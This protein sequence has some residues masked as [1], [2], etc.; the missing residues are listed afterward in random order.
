LRARSPQCTHITRK[1]SVYQYRRR[2]PAPHSGEVMLSLG[3][4]LYREAEHR[5]ALLDETFSRVWERVV[6]M[7]GGLAEVKRVVREYLRDALETDLEWRATRRPGRALFTNAHEDLH[8]TVND[9]DLDILDSLISDARE[10]LERRDFRSVRSTADALLKD[11]RLSEDD[12]NLLSLGLLEANLKYLLEARQRSLGQVSMVLDVGPEPPSVPPATP[13][14]P[15]SPVPPSPANAPAFSELVADFVAWREKSGVRGHTLAQDRPT[16]RFFQEL[17]GDRPVN[18][19]GR[20]DVTRFLSKIQEF[21]ASYGKSPADHDRSAAEIIARANEANAKRVSAKTAKRHLSVLSRF[22]KFCVDQ[23]YI[24]MAQA[25]ELTVKHEFSGG[26]GP[27]RNQRDAWTIEEL[28]TLFASP[29]WTGCHPFFR[30]QPGPTVI[31]DAK[32]WLPLLALFHGSRLEEFADM[33]RQDVG[34]DGDVWFVSITD[35]ERRLKNENALRNVP[36]HPEV[37][38][39][40]FLEYIEKIAPNPADPLFPDIE[41]QGPDAKRGPRITRWFV[42]Y[43]REIGIYRSGVAM[44]AFR[45]TANTRLRDRITDFQ[46]E[47]QVAYMLGHSQGGGEGRERYDKGPGLRAAAETLKLLQYPELDLSH[48]YVTG[49]VE[50]EQAA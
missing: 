20:G 12:R 39:M 40:G 24:S 2:L 5:A 50:G 44:H 37:I 31:R 11:N 15:A 25:T 1:R 38:R 46:Q 19:Y 16:L 13:F 29:V 26:S 36:L 21:P 17:A 10:A 23:G 14:S 8:N 32:F 18:T 22:F 35:E 48:L 4:K 49:A 34:K 27:A 7:S 47:R 41:P 43:R 33:R 45:H 6:G 30:S 28:K 9:V 3:T 42:N